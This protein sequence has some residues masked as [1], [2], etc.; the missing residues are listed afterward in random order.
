MINSLGF[1]DYLFMLAIFLIALGFL[2]YLFRKNKNPC[3]TCSK[4]CKSSDCFK[5]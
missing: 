1:F 5:K 2:V 4:D 3:G